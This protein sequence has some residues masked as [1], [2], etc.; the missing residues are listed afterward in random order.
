MRNFTMVYSDFFESKKLNFYEKTIYIALKKFADNE[1][2]TAYPSVRTISRITGISISKIKESIKNMVDLGAISVNHRYSADYGYMS[3]LYTL[4][5]S[6]D[7]WSD[8][9][10]ADKDNLPKRTHIV[11]Y[12]DFLECD[13]L[14]YFE[15]IIFIAIK[16]FA[17]NKTLKAFPSLRKLKELTG[18]SISQIRRCIKNMHKMGVL[19][20]ERRISAVSGNIS[21]AYTLYDTSKNWI[22]NSSD[23]ATD[24]SEKPK[25]DKKNEPAPTTG[26]A[27]KYFSVDNSKPYQQKNQEKYSMEKIKKLYEYEIMTFDNSSHVNTIDT[28]FSILHETVN[29]TRPTIRVNREDKPAEVVKAKLLK[30]TR[31]EIM[32]VIRQFNKQ[33]VKIQ[34]PTSYLLTQLYN[35]PEQMQLDIANSIARNFGFT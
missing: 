13:K 22:N 27:Q 28:V 1:T 4:N 3:N 20:I 15:K 30:L 5:D 25:M 12:N 34:N 9:A 23:C 2:M 21:N 33:P 16:K 6:R 11:V 35:A 24:N 7:F 19:A 29:S 26:Q 32:F 14:S 31:E 10:A 18:I 17:D 8:D